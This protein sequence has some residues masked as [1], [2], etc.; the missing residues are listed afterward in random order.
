MASGWRV[1]DRPDGYQLVS[2]TGGMPGVATLLN[3][4]PSQNIAV[5]ILSNG[6]AGF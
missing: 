5:V 1:D 3:I 2:H 6:G 4:V